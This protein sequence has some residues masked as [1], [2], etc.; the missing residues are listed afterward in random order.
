MASIRTLKMETDPDFV[1]KDKKC[2]ALLVLNAPASYETEV[3]L[4]DIVKTH[5]PVTLPSI[6]VWG[7]P[8]DWTWEGEQDLF[9]IHHSSGVVIQ[10]EAGHFFPSEQKYYD[11]IVQELDKILS[12]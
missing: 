6:H 7:G 5:G 10:H 11:Q 3:Q 2:K 9:R 4:Q 1:P 12:E 8:T